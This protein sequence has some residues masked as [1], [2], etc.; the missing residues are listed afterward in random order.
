MKHSQKSGKTM[1]VIKRSLAIILSAVIL[2]QQIGVQATEGETGQDVSTGSL[3]DPA[4]S[5][6]IPETSSDD[7]T[8][9]SGD[10]TISSGDAFIPYEFNSEDYCIEFSTDSGMI[11]SLIVAKLK[12]LGTE[13]REGVSV[14]W[15][16]DE[17][18][19][20]PV[21]QTDSTEDA[22]SAKS[23]AILANES[24]IHK[25]SAKLYHE[26][27]YMGTVVS[28][29]F[30]LKGDSTAPLI[31]AV[32][33]AI[34]D[35]EL[36]E[37]TGEDIVWGCGNLILQVKASD[38]VSESEEEATTG[39]SAVWTEINGTKYPMDLDETAGV[40]K[41][42][43]SMPEH[44]YSIV[45][46]TVYA[47]DR[48]DN[49]S[50]KGLPGFYIDKEEPIATLNL[51]NSKGEVQGWYSETVKAEELK[52]NVTIQDKSDIQKIEVSKDDSFTTIVETITDIKGVEA[53]SFV[54]QTGD[55]IITG[56][57]NQIYYVKVYD[58]WGNTTTQS[59]LVT[60]D[61]TAPKD[62]VNVEF[63]VT[64]DMVIELADNAEGTNEY[65]ISRKQGRVYD[66]DKISLMLTME[67][68]AVD[69]VASGIAGVKF[70][71]WEKDGNSGETTR[72]PVEVSSEQ[73][74]VT[75]DGRPY[76]SYD[77]G[78]VDSD[79]FEKSFGICDLYIT[80]VAGNVCPGGI[81]GLQDQVVYYV[82][83]SAPRVEY[84][85]GDEKIGTG[86]EE[87]TANGKVRYFNKPFTSQ[88]TAF[89]A[90]LN[91]LE[92]DNA[93]VEGNQKAQI[94]RIAET[95]DEAIKPVEVYQYTLSSDG[96][97]QLSV[98]A[99]DVLG[100]GSVDSKIQTVLSDEI[101]VDTLAPQI[102]IKVCDGS[103]QVIN[104]YA[105]QY[106]SQNMIINMTIEERNLDRESVQ[107][108]ISGV[109]ATGEAVAIT[110]DPGSWSANGLLYT[111]QYEIAEE[112]YYTVSVTCMDK[113]GNGNEEAIQGFHID[114][115]A[116][117]V[118]ITYDENEPL[119][120]FYYNTVR[121]ATVTVTDY[122]FDATKVN[123]QVK[124]VYGNEPLI[125]EW[126]HLP[127]G[128]CSG[129]N[130]TKN[131]TF[132]VKVK[133]EK[134]DIYDFTFS[135]EDKAGLKSE[136]IETEHFVVDRTA[137]EVSIF[138]DHYEASHDY[139]YKNARTAFVQI[140]DISF[141]EDLVS[142]VKSENPLVNTLPLL[143]GYVGSGKT[144]T[145]SIYFDKD[146]TYQFTVEATDLAGNKSELQLC[147]L[148]I[149]DMT[150]PEIAISGVGNFSA[151]KGNVMPR[152]EYWDKYLSDTESVI[153]ISGYYHGIIK[154][155]F[156]KETLTDGYAVNYE[157]FPHTQDVDDLYT[158]N[159]SIKDFAGNETTDTLVFSV[160]R[161]GSVYVLSKKSKAVLEN[162]YLVQAPE[163]VITEI[164]VDTLEKRQVTNSLDG[165]TTELKEGEDYTVQKQGTEVTWKSYSYIL[166]ADNFETEGHYAI[167]VAS[168]D[169]AKN[170]SDNRS[171]GTEITFAIDKTAP[172]IVVSGIEDHGVYNM[173]ELKVRADIKDNMGL[174]YIVIYDGNTML[175]DY[176]AEAIEDNFGEIT[177][178]LEEGQEARD[179]RIVAQ[180][181]AGNVQEENYEEVTITTVISEITDGVAPLTS[182]VLKQDVKQKTMQIPWI[183]I[184][185]VS[186]LFV[187]IG[188]LYLIKRR[189]SRQ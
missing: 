161:F 132:T 128:P 185:T 167:T 50:S 166:P 78:I 87:E 98:E 67:D 149:V 124:S 110:L 164:N 188:I 162:Y 13:S 39:M 150:A 17:S 60:I 103:G 79:L 58:K 84:T 64:E 182:S 168:T 29:D 22:L 113:A 153:E 10:P 28:G 131:C 26:D 138:F 143:S 158:L 173:E 54:A 119:N 94:L 12:Y 183:L 57:Q 172:S 8:V 66:K 19:F 114:K 20:S 34:G 45:T 5:P 106:F 71:I 112:G 49:T 7:S 133:F 92:V 46:P 148:F 174:E 37:L 147:P 117:I 55:G 51:Q 159:V 81:A 177:F 109:R 151:N 38:V 44:T 41:T 176:D 178:R 14:V 88:V 73:F 80:D 47:S 11:G 77:M 102:E 43:I 27:Y 111:N 15:E 35:Q 180:D 24:S 62:E 160:N 90:N 61:N 123:F 125:G 65:I 74:A 163:I 48:V 70:V 165:V 154:R 86:N 72:T 146:G 96:K 6:D 83:N 56:D 63:C 105:N 42:E 157:D 135:C 171:K 139:F 189:K 152:V 121:T 140:D 179:I 116:P 21:N 68:P 142:V 122:S 118:T 144:H 1:S 169:K 155:D 187:G 53:N 175:Q 59:I 82:D 9:S 33:Y 170:N 85:Y 137:P 107:V 101:V 3:D 31:E 89:D 156:M 186:S 25:I 4:V 134:D 130:H 30:R 181:M 104:E 115:T 40:W 69:G 120:K 99:D 145:A 126:S 91:V 76:I 16:A 36:T 100:N 18:I 184:G 129:S 97:Y 127:D 52:I 23:Y 141:D 108:L 136:A 2:L 32:Y 75:E 93:L 95:E